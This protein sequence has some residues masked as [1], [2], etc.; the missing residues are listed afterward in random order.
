MC[1]WVG[2]GQGT[3]SCTLTPTARPPPTQPRGQPPDPHRTTKPAKP[4]PCN[5]PP[6]AHLRTVRPL[7]RSPTRPMRK[8]SRRPISRWMVYT[9][10]SACNG[11]TRARGR[12]AH[13]RTGGSGTGGGGDGGRGSSPGAA[14]GQQLCCGQHN[15]VW[16]HACEGCCPGPSP[17]LKM[18]TEAAEAARS[19]D[20]ACAGAV[21][22]TQQELVRC[23]HLTDGSSP[24]L[25]ARCQPTLATVPRPAVGSGAITSHLKVP[26]HNHICI[27]L[28][29]ADGICGRCGQDRRAQVSGGRAAVPVAPA[30][31]VVTTARSASQQS[32]FRCRPALPAPCPPPASPSNV[33]PLAALEN[34]PADSV[35]MTVPPRRTCIGAAGANF[36]DREAGTSAARL[37][38]IRRSHQQHAAPPS[39]AFSW[40]NTPLPT[41][42]TAACAWRA[43]R[44]VWT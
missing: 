19:A 32:R 2:G 27:L 8:L 24:L 41:Q 31:L 5:P 25:V 42:R 37:Q 40:S 14:A 34:S 13:G 38:A 28:Y 33:S 44:R 43:R 29:C 4:N 12:Q 20:P 23:A 3:P 7:A 30:R 22:A 35:L 10:S 18:G 21:W 39:C 9:S 11:A 26:Q 16:P 17:A 1:V 6:T 15:S 36:T